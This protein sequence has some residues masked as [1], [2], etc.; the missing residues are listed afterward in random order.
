[1]S[2]HYWDRYW[3]T[4]RNRR[5]V[6]RG[7]GVAS[8]GAASM[9][10]V[11]CGGDDSSDE[12]D[13]SSLATPTTAPNPAPTTAPADPFAGA[14]KG[15]TYKLVLTGDPPTIDPMGNLSFLTR[16]VGCYVHSRLFRYKAGPGISATDVKPEGD[17]AESSEV[18]AD[19]L[20]WTIKLRPAK[21]HNIAPVNGRVLNTDDIKYSWARMTDE[22]NTN[23]GN[24]NFVDKVEYPDA[25][26]VVFSLK[27]PNAGFKELLTDTTNLIIMPAEADGKYDPNQQMIGTGPWVFQSYQ[28]SV[29]FKFAKN[30]DWFVPGFPLFDEIDYAVVPD[31]S[32]RL[33]QFLAGN[34]D[35]EGLNAADLV[36][37][38]RQVS[39]LQLF[40]YVAPQAN[41]IWFDNTPNAPW[42]DPRV[43]Q[44]VSMSFPRDEITDLVYETTKL[45]A[46]GIDVKGPWNNLI[47]AGLTRFWLDPQGPDMGDSAKFFKYDPAEAKK[48]L[49]AAGHPN[50]FETVYQYTANRY[51]KGFNDA[52][53]ATQNFLNTIGVKTTTDV[54]DYSSKYITQTFVGNF[55]GIVFG[56]ETSFTDVGGY[57][58]RLFTDNASNHARI[59]DPK[60]IEMHAKQQQ[61]LDEAKRKAII[62]DMQRHNAEQMYYIPGQVGAGTT[63]TGHQANVRNGVEYVVNGYGGGTEVV[64][65]RWK[66]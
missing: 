12:N 60:L 65:Y 21:F 53:E 4:R 63:W 30:P 45:K 5:V 7:A 35:S 2:E 26:T 41:Y 36:D 19:G 22:K 27:T 61:E 64:P 32:N 38:K 25:S 11:G 17:L 37:S 1:M 34:T 43:R 48:L 42:R 31:Y 33:A 59:N 66:A 54:Q 3:Q 20:K 52:A 49:E 29:G 39:G 56:L 16:G 57:S 6:L 44:A 14:K 40:G 28:P 46:A 9:A 50:G 18:S 23:R 15:G 13:A 51:G 58:A 24:F 55:T 10:A 47:P 8:L 62:W